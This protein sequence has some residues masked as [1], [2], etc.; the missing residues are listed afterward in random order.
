MKKTISEGNCFWDEKNAREIAVQEVVTRECYFCSV[1]E[2]NAKSN[3]FEIA[4]YQYFTRQELHALK[5]G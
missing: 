5:E 1:L 3:E 4:G 2:F